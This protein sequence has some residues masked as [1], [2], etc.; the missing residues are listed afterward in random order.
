[1]DKDDDPLLNLPID[2]DN[3]LND[4]KEK[5][6]LIAKFDD[7]KIKYQNQK[8]LLETMEQELKDSKHEK[9]LLDTKLNERDRKIFEIKRSLDTV[10]KNGK[11][12]RNTFCL[13]LS[14][15]MSS[16]NEQLEN[17]LRKLRIRI[18]D[19]FDENNFTRERVRTTYTLT[20]G[21]NKNF[22]GGS[23]LD[24]INEEEEIDVNLK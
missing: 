1:M 19:L 13:K 18:M 23:N 14:E 17:V 12:F 9:S 24:A 2:N 5:Q 8:D 20:N 22:F 4:L 11:N 15:I 10:K 7:L 3:L 16:E 21:R 6:D